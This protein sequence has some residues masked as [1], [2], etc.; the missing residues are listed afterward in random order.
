MSAT[1]RD[2]LVEL[3]TEEL[4]PLALPE[5]E[6]A[7]AAGIR[8]GL[9]QASLPHGELTSFATPRR[10]AVLVRDLAV[11]QP[12]Q[13][14]KLKGP[15]VSAAFDKDGKPTAAATKFAEKCGAAVAALTR[16]TEGKGEFLFFAGSKAGLATASLLPAIVQRSLDQLPIPKRM[17]WGSSSAEFVRPVHWLTLLF[18]AEVIPARILDTDAG[19][20]TRGHRFMAPQDFPLAEPAAYE[21]TLRDKGKVIANFGARRALIREQVA[22]AAASL[23]GE[24]LLGDSLLDEVTAL[25]EW[26][27]AIAGSFEARFL[28]LPRE[29]LISTLQQHQR[30]FPVQGGGAK[31]LPHFITVSNI[32]SRDP[33]IVR[34]GNERVVRPRLSD[35]A[36]FWS[37][38]RKQPLAA[39]LPGLDA[40]TFQA[41]LGSIGDKVR[42]VVTLAGEIALLI[43]ANQAQAQR[44]ATLAKCDLLS[45][46]VGEFP[47]LQ[48]IMGRYYALA[49]GE[50]FDVA[51]AID[52]HYLPRAS[53]GALPA[54]AAGVAVAL[55]DKLDT[56]AGIFAIGQKPSGTKDPFGLRRAAIGVLRI[57]TEKKFDLDLRALV[58]RACELQPVQNPGAQPELWDYLVERLRAHFLDAASTGGVAG[59]TTEMFDAV[60]ASSPVSPLDFAARLTALA[61][62][63]GLPE[64]ASLTAAYK[65]ISNIL[66][67]AELGTIGTVNVSALVEPAEKALHEALAGIVTEVDRA[68]AKRDYSAA[69]TRLATLRPA[70]DGFFD[71]VLVNAEDV[72]LRRNRLALLAHLRHHFTRIADLSCLP[73]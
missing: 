61:K 17:R 27:S 37:Q 55:A 66:K 25:V 28:E 38:D 44:A 52:E 30:Y 62:F 16:V 41:K 6:Q 18:G 32:E 72:A 40:V 1:T 39:R 68:L 69:L 56:L 54:T 23:S 42:R 35:A 34:A 7:F 50:P 13:T 26:P 11:M 45:A 8:T 36:F 5:L 43:D 29:V 58:T 10:L 70:V 57:L 24:A 59:V 33:S 2:F 20:A 21:A 71:A 3:G 64:A 49:D 51:A 48:G 63:L 12:A 15:P 67:K 73:G 60:R 53:G 19:N 65:R 31:L 46:M 14:I 22:A 47:E 4:P 9:A